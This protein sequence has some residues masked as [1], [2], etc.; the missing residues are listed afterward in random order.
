MTN[1]KHLKK[2]I[3][4]CA[5]VSILTISTAFSFSGCNTASLTGNAGTTTQATSGS[6]STSES[7]T[8]SDSSSGSKTS[9]STKSDSKQ[10]YSYT[11]EDTNTEVGDNAATITCS[12]KTAKIDGKGAT[13]KDGTITISSAGTYV[14]TGDL[15]GQVVVN[16][17]KEDTVHII[18]KN[19]SITSSTSAAINA[20][21][22]KKLVITLADG[23]K[24]TLTDASTYSGQDEKGDPD[25]ALFSKDSITINGTGSLTVNGNSKHGI[26]S[27]NNLV[28]VSGTLNVTAQ[29]D[30][31]KGK[32]CVVIKDGTIKVKAGQDGIQA[33]NTKNDT[34]GFVWVAGGTTEISCSKQGIQAAST[35]QIDDGKITVT[36]SMEGLEGEV[37]SINGGTVDITSS[38][39]GINAAQADSSSSSN[40]QTDKGMGGGGNGDQYIKGLLI[41]INGGSVTINAEGDGIDSNGD[42]EVTGGTLTLTGPSRGGNGILDYNGTATISGGTVVAAGTSD[43][44]QTFADSSKQCSLIYYFSETQKSGTTVSLK[45]SS[46]NTLTSMKVQKDYQAAIFSTSKMKQGETYSV[47]VDNT[48]IEDVKLSGISNSS[49]TAQNNRGGNGDMQPGGGGNRPDG[50]APGGQ[51]AG[52]NPPDRNSSDSNANSNSNSNSNKNSNSNS[53]NNSSNNSNSNS[54]N[55]SSSG[56]SQG[57]DL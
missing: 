31:I 29:T 34:K 53:S 13:C 42:L 44:A 48:K 49:G 47:Y 19:C 22:S 32:D 46:G 16:T 23:T 12:E 33:N 2:K 25:A 27:K 50:N 40:T 11:D 15:S 1:Y 57:G 26:H 36:N 20:T 39:D 41:S 37:V 9:T 28:I 18:L 51:G 43:M 3:A 55:N 38:D 24:N 35:C 30:G 10:L 21:Q 45:D 7:T 4:A 56:N 8:A 52:G 5:A 17:G 54:S 6:A 14:L